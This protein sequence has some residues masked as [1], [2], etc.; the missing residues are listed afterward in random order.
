VFAVL[1]TV[2]KKILIGADSEPLD[3]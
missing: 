1:K 2:C 3:D